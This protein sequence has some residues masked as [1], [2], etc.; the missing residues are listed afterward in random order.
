MR[1]N[2]ISIYNATTKDLE[3]I[4]FEIFV[5]S[6]KEIL[7]EKSETNQL[8]SDLINYLQINNFKNQ[9]KNSF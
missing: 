1:S 2:K 4:Q 9:F 8:K 5:E 3:L 7:A 6:L